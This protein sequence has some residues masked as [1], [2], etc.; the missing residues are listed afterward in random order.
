[1]NSKAIRAGF[2]SDR[3]ILHSLQVL[4][5]SRLLAVVSERP[6]PACERLFTKPLMSE[7]TDTSCES[8]RTCVCALVRALSQVRSSDPFHRFALAVT[9]Q[10]QICQ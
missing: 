5:L 4:L 1:M 8:A 2:D 6:C 7:V 9:A 10:P 3:S